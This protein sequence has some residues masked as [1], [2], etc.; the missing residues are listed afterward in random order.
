MGMVSAPVVTVLA[1][2]EPETEPSAAEAT[3]AAFAGPPRAPSG[4]REGQVDEEPAAAGAF[5]QGA[6]EDEDEDRT[7]RHADRKPEEARPGEDLETH[8]ALEFETAVRQDAGK[9]GPE[10]VVGEEHHHHRGHHRA[11]PPAGGFQQERDQGDAGN[12]VAGVQPVENVVYP[13]TVETNDHDPGGDGESGQQEIPGAFP[14]R[15]PGGARQEAERQDPGQ[16]DR[17]HPGGPE[18]AENG[19]PELEQREGRPGQQ[20]REGEGGPGFFG[21]RDGPGGT[22]RAVQGRLPRAAPPR[23]RSSS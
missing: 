5:E 10:R 3:T 11:H 18:G 23:S 19:L 9:G 22:R 21:Q 12:E 20:H 16:V 2:A 6:E 14:R 17:P 13:L 8:D 15:A 4:G 1:M 7:A